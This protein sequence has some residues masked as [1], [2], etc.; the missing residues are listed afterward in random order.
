MTVGGEEGGGLEYGGVTVGGEE[1]GGLEK[2]SC[3]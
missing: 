3:G 2:G 1:G